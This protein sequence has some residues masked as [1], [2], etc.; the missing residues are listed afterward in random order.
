MYVYIIYIEPICS[1]SVSVKVQTSHLSKTLSFK[2]FFYSLVNIPN[3][4]HAHNL[5]F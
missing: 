3:Y 2:L 5:M 1:I 4:V